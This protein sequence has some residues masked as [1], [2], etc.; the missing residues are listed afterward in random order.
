MRV[1]VQL[2]VLAVLT[3]PAVA[4]FATTGGA[5][6]SNTPTGAGCRPGG[7]GLRNTFTGA[8]WGTTR[9]REVVS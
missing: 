4:Y 9:M 6:A 2:M 5:A 7:A 1:L 3:M 8:G